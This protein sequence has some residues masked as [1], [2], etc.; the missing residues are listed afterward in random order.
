MLRTA[1]VAMPMQAVV[2]IPI[3][4]EQRFCCTAFP[5]LAECGGREDCAGTFVL[6]SSAIV[7]EFGADVRFYGSAWFAASFEK[8]E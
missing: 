1:D 5:G 2:V 7:P 3:T 4:V 8:W 6:G